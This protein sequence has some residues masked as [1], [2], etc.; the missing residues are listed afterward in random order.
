MRTEF[1]LY[2][3]RIISSEGH[4]LDV[5]TGNGI[6]GAW[7]ELVAKTGVAW[8]YQIAHRAVSG[9]GVWLSHYRPASSPEILHLVLV[10]PVPTDQLPPP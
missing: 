10:Q 2:E 7:R 3:Y 6:K 9:T 5:G 4:L 1:P 8:S